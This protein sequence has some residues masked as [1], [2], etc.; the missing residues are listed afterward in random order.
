[1]GSSDALARQESNRDSDCSTCILSWRSIP[2]RCLQKASRA[3]HGDANGICVVIACLAQ[4]SMRGPTLSQLRM[5][6]ISHDSPPQF[7]GDLATAALLLVA[8]SWH[9]AQPALREL[10]SSNK[11]RQSPVIRNV[12]RKG[13]ANSDAV[14]REDAV[15]C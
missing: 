4:A 13:A 12:R 14:S 11:K 3:R 15:A 2:H 10:I 9:D 1:M 5:M 7:A 8:Q 6:K